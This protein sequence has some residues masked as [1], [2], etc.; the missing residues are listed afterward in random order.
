M[1]PRSR[2]AGHRGREWLRRS[3]TDSTRLLG[4]DAEKPC[5]P[6][7]CNADGRATGSQD[8]N[9]GGG[10]EDARRRSAGRDGNRGA[11]PLA[12]PV[13]LSQALPTARPPRS[14][15]AHRSHP[16]HRRL[17]KKSRVRKPVRSAVPGSP[18]T[19]LELCNRHLYAKPA[20]SLTLKLLG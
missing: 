20:E 7:A 10:T 12:H 11:A 9:H 16:Q 14:L 4:R 8:T 17:A 6:R 1:A 13:T 3:D 15:H 2:N 5:V 19:V 18:P